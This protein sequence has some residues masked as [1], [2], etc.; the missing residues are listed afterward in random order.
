MCVSAVHGGTKQ[1]WLS[2]NCHV[3][4]YGLE[5]LVGSTHLEKLYLSETSHISESVAIPVL[6][7]ILDTEGGSLSAMH[8]PGHWKKEGNPLLAQLIS[9]FNR[10]MDNIRHIACAERSWCN[11][12]S[13]LIKCGKKC[14]STADHPWMNDNGDMTYHF[15]CEQYECGTHYCAA[16]VRI[17]V[18]L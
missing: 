2:D 3:T 17:E 10:T 13:K 4:G 6:C 12:T 5:P 9:K 14:H 15:T 16:C 1:V 8:L 11:D 18:L 7:R